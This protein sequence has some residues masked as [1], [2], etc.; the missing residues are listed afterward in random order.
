VS[1]IDIFGTPGVAGVYLSTNNGTSWTAFNNGLI[2]PDVNAL[3]VSGS[4]IF[5][6]SSGGGVFVSPLP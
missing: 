5:A 4:N 2:N 1:G 3:V 6:G